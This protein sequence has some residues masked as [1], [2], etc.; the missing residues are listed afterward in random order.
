MPSEWTNIRV[1]ECE[2]QDG[3]PVTVIKQSDGD[4]C[5]YVLGNG[6]PVAHNG[7]GT[8]TLPESAEVLNLLS[9]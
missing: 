2:S 6:R 8:F 7:D 4:E 9:F 1:F 3:E 5:R